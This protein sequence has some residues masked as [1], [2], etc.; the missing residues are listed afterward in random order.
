MS[1]DPSTS[2]TTI[3]SKFTHALEDIPSISPDRTKPTYTTIYHFLDKLLENA[4]SIP[5]PGTE[6][7]HLSLVLTNLEYLDINDNIPFEPPIDPGP[8][9]DTPR[10]ADPATIQQANRD[11][12][13]L[14]RNYNTYI[15][16]KKLLRNMIIN[17]VDD[18]YIN[19]LKHRITKYANVN[20]ITIITHLKQTYGQIQ[21]SD[22]TANYK[23][24]TIPWNPPAPI[25]QLWKQL[26]DGQNFAQQGNE[27]ISN[28]TLARLGYENIL[29]TGLFDSS[30]KK[31][32]A[33]APNDQTFTELQVFFAHEV[34]DYEAHVPTSGTRGYANSTETIQDIVHNELQQIFT[35]HNPEI[36]SA[37]ANATQE[38]HPNPV[39]PTPTPAPTAD[40]VISELRNLVNALSTTNTSSQNH[41]NTYNRRPY[42][43]R[44]RLPRRNTSRPNVPAQGLDENGI[45]VSYCWSHGITHNLRHTSKSCTRPKDGHQEEAT[46]TN[47]MGG[48]AHRLGT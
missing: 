16:T 18:M 13:T 22:K 46:Y 2:T 10:G 33:R 38:T 34:T 4:S 15:D 47:Q 11:H 28:E 3:A 17:K 37:Q 31:W 32:R 45:P 23:R 19:S 41:S 9:V 48:C 7:G 14:T 20:P 35:Q 26:Q 24:M 30:C 1:S 5:Y 42:N 6:L 39:E 21:L 40:P 44:N 12:D 27:P 29:A 43:N 36:F 8:T 25:E